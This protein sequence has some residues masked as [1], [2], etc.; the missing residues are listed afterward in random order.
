MCTG[1]HGHFPHFSA[2]SLCCLQLEIRTVALSVNVLGGCVWHRLG[3][4]EPKGSLFIDTRVYRKKCNV[5]WAK[6]CRCIFIFVAHFDVLAQ[7]AI[8][9]C[10]GLSW[11]QPR[12]EESLGSSQPEWLLSL[13]QN[14]V[15]TVFILQGTELYRRKWL[16]NCWAPVKHRSSDSKLLVLFPPWCHRF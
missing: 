15:F 11:F 10:S 1:V 13:E 2:L 5:Q 12:P 8:L 6:C 9:L 16:V 3:R 7:E 14:T 4:L